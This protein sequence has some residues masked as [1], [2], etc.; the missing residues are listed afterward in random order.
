M[1]IRRVDDEIRVDRIKLCIF[2]RRARLQREDELVLAA[3]SRK[4]HRVRQ[5]R[6]QIFE[7]LTQ[8]PHHRPWLRTQRNRQI[9]SQVGLSW[10]TDLAA[11]QVAHTRVQM[12]RPRLGSLRSGQG[13]RKGHRILVAI[14]HQRTKRQ[15]CRS[16]KLHFA[17]RDLS[18]QGPFHL[19]RHAGVTRVYP[20]D[21]P[22]LFERKH[23]PYL[24]RPTWRNRRS[25]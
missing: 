6:R 16:W 13:K 10:N 14:I 22:M 19:R 1:L 2:L 15:P 24:L 8:R 25:Q 7:R 17:N 23:Q 12:N 4:L 21:M 18:R 3:K 20:V 5:R 9:E 11:D